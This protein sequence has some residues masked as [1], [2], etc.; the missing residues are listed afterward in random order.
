MTELLPQSADEL[1]DMVARATGPLRIEGGG[2]RPIGQLRDGQVLRTTGLNGIDLYEPGALTLVAKAGTPLAEVEKTLAAEGQRLAFEPMD[3][4]GVLG[5]TGQPTVGGMVAANVS[6][7]RRIQVGACRDSLLGVKFVDGSGQLIS[8]GG[9][10]MKNVTGYDL[11]KLMAGSYGTLG[12]LSEVA[13]KVLPMPETEQTLILHDTPTA[14]AIDAM[15]SALG[16]PWEVTGAAHIP[17]TANDQP[18]TMLRV[19]GTQA[20]VAYRIDALKTRLAEYGD[21]NVVEH[22]VSRVA[23]QRLRDLDMFGDAHTSGDV[24]RISLKPTDAPDFLARMGDGPRA[25]LDWGGGLIWLLCPEETGITGTAIRAALTEIG[26]GHATL[27]RGQDAKA[28]HPLPKPLEDLQRGL[29]QKFDPRGI[30]NPGLMGQM[31]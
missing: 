24:W 21:M 22:D 25:Q 29:R 4:R 5:T 19:E 17:L 15:S 31:A 26:G 11:V 30:L 20:S 13:L 3:H 10:V 9:R 27:I 23:W 6:G 28:F 18:D 7:P 8:N 1:G 14:Q 2:T 12:V 16:S